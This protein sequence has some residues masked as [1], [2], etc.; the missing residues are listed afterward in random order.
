MSEASARARQPID[1]EEFER[2]LRGSA[3]VAPFERARIE[4][5]TLGDYARLMNSTDADAVRALGPADPYA[6]Q[7]RAPVDR[8]PLNPYAPNPAAQ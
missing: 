4:P 5:Q 3:A 6:P 8:M 7:E 1:L 2:R